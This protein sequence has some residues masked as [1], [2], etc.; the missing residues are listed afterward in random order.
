MENGVYSVRTK[1]P[2]LAKHTEKNSARFIQSTNRKVVHARQ[3]KRRNYG[4]RSWNHKSKQ[5]LHTCFT[6][7]HVTRRVIR[8]ILERSRVRIYVRRL[9]NTLLL[10]RSQ[11][12]TL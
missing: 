2:V 5:E 12:A 8:K 9:L 3:L 10:M 11:F 7:M 1:R 4:L 6:K